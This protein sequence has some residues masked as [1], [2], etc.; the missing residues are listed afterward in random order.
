[1]MIKSIL[2]LIA[3]VAFFASTTQAIYDGSRCQQYPDGRVTCVGPLSPRFLSDSSKMPKRRLCSRGDD[4]LWCQN[5]DIVKA[6]NTVLSDHSRCVKG[7]DGRNR[8]YGPALP[9]RDYTRNRER[10]TPSSSVLSDHRVLPGRRSRFMTALSDSEWGMCPEGI[11]GSCGG[12]APRQKK[13]F[14]FL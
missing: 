3:L 14:L 1:M 5:W 6:H 2:V 13:S 8:C 4:R 9:P 12:T 11:S 10:A 7:K